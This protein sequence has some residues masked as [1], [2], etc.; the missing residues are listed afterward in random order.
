MALSTLSWWWIN[1]AKTWRRSALSSSDLV[2]LWQCAC[3]A[4]DPYRAG[5]LLTR[6]HCSH[7]ADTRSLLK[8]G[9]RTVAPSVSSTPVPSAG[10]Y[11]GASARLAIVFE[12]HAKELLGRSGPLTALL[13]WSFR[14]SAHPPRNLTLITSSL[15][16]KCMCAQVR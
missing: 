12:T 1:V 3:L 6:R 11:S 9:N 7:S 8:T 10:E 2:C 5:W 4:D 14:L 13:K 16:V 15:Y